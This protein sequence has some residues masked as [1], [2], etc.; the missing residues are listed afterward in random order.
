MSVTIAT[1]VEINDERIKDLLCTA[2]EGGS[3][4]WIDEVILPDKAARK[5]AGAEFFHESPLVGLELTVV[6]AQGR[7][8]LNRAALERGLQIMADK[9]PKHFSD[10][11][12]DNADA[13]TGDLFLQC[14]LFGEEV[15][16]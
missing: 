1:N 10:I 9:Y 4:Y 3:N 11:I 2:F 13:I 8:A 12:S 6:S 7:H 16:A 5:A 14:C 15:F